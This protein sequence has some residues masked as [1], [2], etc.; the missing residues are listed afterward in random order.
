M[1]CTRNHSSYLSLILSQLFTYRYR[2]Q[3]SGQYKNVPHPENTGNIKPF[4]G[5]KYPRI[6][7]ALPSDLLLVLLVLM[8]L[9]FRSCP[10]NCI[11]LL[12]LPMIPVKIFCICSHLL[13]YDV[14]TAILLH[15][16]V[17]ISDITTLHIIHS[18]SYASKRLILLYFFASDL[19]IYSNSSCISCKIFF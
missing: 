17:L 15:N 14:N 5:Y 16:V 7:A 2:I 19:L 11:S 18:T 8:L 4:L 10:W 3:N 6:P 9:S 13:Y 1:G 12:F